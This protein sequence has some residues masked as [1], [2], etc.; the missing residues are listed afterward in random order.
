MGNEGILYKLLDI[1]LQLYGAARGRP[2]INVRIQED[3]IKQE[4][5]GLR[6]EI[7]NRR[8]TVTSLDPKIVV[9]Y[10]YVEGDKL[11][12]GHNLYFVRE[13]DRRLDPFQPKLLSASA[14]ERSTHY[15]LGVFRTYTF[16]PTSGLKTRVR[17]RSIL[18][19]TLSLPQFYWELAWLRWFKKFHADGPENMEDYKRT[20]RARGPH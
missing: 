5:G 16:K 8:W 11:R 19:E 3:D 15:W 12:Q 14:D 7:E 2:R 1:L 10:R 13:V 9:S 18:L 6:F 17:V 20:K 4:V